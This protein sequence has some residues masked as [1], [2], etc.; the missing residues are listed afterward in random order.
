M[1]KR[2]EKDRESPM[3]KERKKNTEKIE[4]QCEL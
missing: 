4:K 3:G 1:S 2:R